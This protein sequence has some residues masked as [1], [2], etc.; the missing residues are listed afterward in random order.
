MITPEDDDSS[1]Y[2]CETTMHRWHCW[3]EAHRLGIDG[4]LKSIGHRLLGFSTELLGSRMPLLDKL[5]SSRSEWMETLL[6]F[7][8]DSGGFWVPV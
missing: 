3:M 6:R 7:V 1:D 8:Y 4:Y 2:P 5:R